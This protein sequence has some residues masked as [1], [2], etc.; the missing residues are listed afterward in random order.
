ML[1]DGSAD[2][3]FDK[4]QHIAKRILNVELVE[5]KIVKASE[6]QSKPDIEIQTNKVNSNYVHAV[7]LNENT[8]IQV[9]QSFDKIVFQ[10]QVRLNIFWVYENVTD[11]LKNNA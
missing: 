7:P 3:A 9:T 8:N 11:D 10:T 6:D 4:S 5:I 2:S 1:N